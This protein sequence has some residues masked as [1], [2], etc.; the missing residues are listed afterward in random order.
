VC[1]S[2]FQTYLIFQRDGERDKA[3]GG[4]END[5]SLSRGTT[6]SISSISALI[7]QPFGRVAAML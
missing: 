7:P 6:G 4:L 1:R 5:N 2:P 3:A